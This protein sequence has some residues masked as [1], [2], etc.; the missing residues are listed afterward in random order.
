[1]ITLNKGLE[2]SSI[3][4]R[5]NTGKFEVAKCYVVRRKTKMNIHLPYTLQIRHEHLYEHKASTI[6]SSTYNVFA[7]H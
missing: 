1:M 5:K 6:T 3:E 2:T 4:K 7:N